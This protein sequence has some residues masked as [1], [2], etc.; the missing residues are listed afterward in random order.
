MSTTT[1]AD[2]TTTNT[3]TI[4]LWTCIVGYLVYRYYK[5]S[6]ADAAIALVT[7]KRGRRARPKT[8]RTPQKKTRRSPVTRHTSRR[9]TLDMDSTLARQN[10]PPTEKPLVALDHD[11]TFSCTSTDQNEHVPKV[12][13]KDKL[14]TAA[15]KCGFDLAQ[16]HQ[17]GEEFVSKLHAK[18][19]S[20]ITLTQNN[21]YNVRAGWDLA[22]MSAECFD[23]VLSVHD[24]EEQRKADCLEPFDKYGAKSFLL[25][26]YMEEHDHHYAVFVDDN[27]KECNAM[28][29]AFGERTEFDPNNPARQVIVVQVHRPARDS[30]ELPGLFNYPGTV[31]KIHTALN[32]GYTLPAH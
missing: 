29:K 27:E 25:R 10:N 13:H 5:D 8:P 14:E 16:Y 24:I 22:G 9:R 31:A 2:D 20:I 28:R 15:A 18:G 17:D 21:E 3:T 7:P 32:G 19:H 23:A 12:E 26:Q 6:A 4:V 30:S 11:L 1:T